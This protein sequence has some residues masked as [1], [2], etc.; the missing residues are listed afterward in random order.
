MQTYRLLFFRGGQLDHWEMID[1]PDQL[2]ALEEASRRPSE[3]LMELWFQDRKIASF[4]PVGTHSS[5]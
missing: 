2:T 5:H 1:A 4:R 3:G